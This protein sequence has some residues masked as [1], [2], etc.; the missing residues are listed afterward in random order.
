L[1][2]LLTGLVLANFSS[3]AQPTNASDLADCGFDLKTGYPLQ[4]QDAYSI[5]V[6]E[7]RLQ[8]AFI[9]DRRVGTSSSHGDLFSM[10]PEVQWGIT[11]TAYLHALVPVYTGSGPTSTSGDVVLGAFWN[12]LSEANGRPAMGISA[13]FEIPTGTH[14]RGLDTLLYYYVS[15]SVGSGIAHDAVHANIGW[16]HNSGNYNEER[17]N[18]YVLRAGYSRKML[19]RTL[20]GID[21]V[22]QKIRQQNITENIFELGLL[23]S[24]CRGMNLSLTAGLG[25]ADESPDWRLGGG[26]QFKWH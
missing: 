10:S 2:L 19:P 20:I 12:F 5:P 7:V 18:F 21:F 13:D 4:V 16:V 15:K 8:S 3:R 11:P 6:G 26:V 17:E 9:F 14:S 22:R 23:H 25:C 1:A 24:V